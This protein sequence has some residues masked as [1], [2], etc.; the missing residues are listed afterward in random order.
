MT[1]PATDNSPAP[2]PE[3]TPPLPSRAVE[4][5]ILDRES[6]F[7]ADLRRARPIVWWST[8]LGPFAAT[9]AMLAWL[10]IDRG[11]DFVLKL[12]AKAAAT[13]F[14]LGRFVILFGSD[15]GDPEAKAAIMTSRELFV[16]VT[17][18]D[19]FAACLLIFHA[20]FMFKV[21]RF[22]PAMLRLREDGEFILQSHRWMKRFTFIGLV[23][24]VA[25]PIAV[26]GSVAGSL[27]GPLVGLSRGATLVGLVVGSVV[28]NA[29]MLLGKQVVNRVPLFRS[30][31][32]LNL[33]AGIACVVAIILLLN[34]RYRR[35]KKRWAEQGQRLGT[36]PR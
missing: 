22:G 18:M 27:F 11:G 36:P 16:M 9:L 7:A 35:L 3:R 13:F 2:P 8:L 23:L 5:E 33:V 26:T 17:W 19:L 32:P 21:P 1:A 30:D 4:V 31:N 28:G 34:W 15:S 10:W 6:R 29:L 12:I 25:F 24:F 20:S 14:G